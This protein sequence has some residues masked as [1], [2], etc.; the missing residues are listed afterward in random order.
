[1][2]ETSIVYFY[3][4]VVLTNAFCAKTMNSWII[5]QWKY[6]LLRSKFTDIRSVVFKFGIDFPVFV[7][8]SAYCQKYFD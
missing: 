4:P 1:M 2:Q 3:L 5:R 8:M 6:R 7:F